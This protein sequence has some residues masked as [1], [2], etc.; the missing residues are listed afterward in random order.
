MGGLNFAHILAIAYSL[1]FIVSPVVKAGYYPSQALDNF[2]TSA[3]DTSFLTHII[4]VLLVP[5]NVTFKFDISNSTASILSN[6]TTLHRKT[7]T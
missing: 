5:N 4:Y 1:F 3:I 6:F 7:P 2:P